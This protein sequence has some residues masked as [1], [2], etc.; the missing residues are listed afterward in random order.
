MLNL[1]LLNDLMKAY[2]LCKLT[3]IYTN[4]LH[5][6]SKNDS[7]ICEKYQY[8]HYWNMSIFYGLVEKRGTYS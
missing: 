6:E 7:C 4:N 8:H 3:F 2:A 1:I 5:F